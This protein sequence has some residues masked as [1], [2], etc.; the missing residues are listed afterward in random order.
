MQVTSS[1]S[2]LNIGGFSDTVFDLLGEFAKGNVNG[3]AWVKE[4]DN[5][6]L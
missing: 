1:K 6:S 3:D 2:T 5:V 4:V